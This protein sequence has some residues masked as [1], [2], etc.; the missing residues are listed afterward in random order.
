MRPAEAN[1]NGPVAPAD[2][3][4]FLATYHPTTEPARSLWLNGLREFTIDHFGKLTFT[5]P[6]ALR[7]RATQ[8]TKVS[9]F[10]IAEGCPL[11]IE[12]LWSPPRIDRY[13]AEHP[14][15]LYLRS[16]L[17]LLAR[18]VTKRAPWGAPP[19][20]DTR[21]RTQW[22]P[23][24]HHEIREFIRQARAQSSR[25]KVRGALA[26]LAMGYGAGLRGDELPWVQARDLLDVEH[27]MAVQV[28]PPWTRQVPLL[29]EMEP[30]ARELRDGISPEDWLSGRPPLSA[31]HIARG[32]DLP[33][34]VNGGEPVRACR[35]RATWLVNHLQRGVPIGDVLV[36][37]G[38]I[39]PRTLTDIFSRLT[40]ST[41]AIHHQLLKGNAHG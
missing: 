32:F 34:A 28:G 23:Y 7:T 12:Q 29:T 13:L 3:A 22:E 24:S 2:V 33:A 27:G 17:V 14:D 1:P 11:D 31:Y 37:A 6:K 25:P 19:V 20:R 16:N 18:Q 30:I 21:T 9:A 39:D 4:A 36:A 26:L 41:H 8:F 5:S 10:G 40:P 35:L 38:R 15:Q